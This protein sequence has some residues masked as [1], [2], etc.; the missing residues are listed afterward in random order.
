MR[1]REGRGERTEGRGG[2]SS[3]MPGDLICKYCQTQSRLKFQN[4]LGGREYSGTLGGKVECGLREAGDLLLDKNA[5]IPW[6]SDKR[7]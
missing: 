5:I 2:M 4:Y 1:L 3:N 7:K 6:L